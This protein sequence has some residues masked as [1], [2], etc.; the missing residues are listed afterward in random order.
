MAWFRGGEHLPE[1]RRDCLGV[2]GVDRNCPGELGK[3]IYYAEK[4]LHSIL[5]PGND[6][7]IG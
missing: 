1:S 5:L 4:V 3:Y 2:L 7:H 6:L